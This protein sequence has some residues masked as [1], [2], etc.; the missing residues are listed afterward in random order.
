MGG[1]MNRATQA[2]TQGAYA[3]YFYIQGERIGIRTSFQVKDELEPRAVLS[4]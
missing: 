1:H 4:T 3:R 2:F